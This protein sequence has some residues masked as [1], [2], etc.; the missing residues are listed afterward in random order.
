MKCAPKARGWWSTRYGVRRHIKEEYYN[1]ETTGSQS[2]IG[3][4]ARFWL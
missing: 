4:Y 3:G 2:T 1:N